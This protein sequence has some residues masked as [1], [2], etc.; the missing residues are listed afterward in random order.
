MVERCVVRDEQ[1]VVLLCHSFGGMAGCQAVNGL[2]ASARA[3]AGER[4]GVQVVVFLNAFIV[5]EGE[6]ARK[7]SRECWSRSEIRRGRP[8]KFLRAT[9]PS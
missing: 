2:E 6:S 5:K 7:R 4:G 8:G 3:E 9:R 1:D